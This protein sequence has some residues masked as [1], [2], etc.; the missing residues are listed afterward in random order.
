M[1]TIPVPSIANGTP[2][3]EQ[4]KAWLEANGID[5]DLIPFGS[6]IEVRDGLIK[7]EEVAIDPETG[8]S[9][10]DEASEG[11]DG[12][13]QVVRVE[14]SLPLAATPEEFGI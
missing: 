6:E 2:L 5:P 8:L 4:A 1:R 7:F 11:E 12:C 10:T 9:I 14:R 13:F 3:F